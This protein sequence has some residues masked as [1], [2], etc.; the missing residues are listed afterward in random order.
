M[1]IIKAP[2]KSYAEIP[3]TSKTKFSFLKEESDHFVEL[4]YPVKCR[5]FLGDSVYSTNEGKSFIT[6]GFQ[7]PTNLDKDKTK[8]RITSEDTQEIQNILKNLDYLTNI[9]VKNKFTP[10][11]VL[12]AEPDIILLGDPKWISNVA[13][14]S[15]Y[16]YLIRRL[17]YINPKPGKIT[18]GN[19]LDYEQRLGENYQ[20]LLDNISKIAI[21]V[22][23][24]TGWSDTSPSCVHNSS[25]FVS[26][27]R[28]LT[29]NNT[30]SKLFFE[31]IVK[32]EPMPIM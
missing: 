10:T 11:V 14:I 12:Y 25:G 26:L 1:N 30:L 9:E 31:E 15:L 29:N 27:F 16:S 22:I 23:N 7:S 20:I 19:E 13:T 18:S 21:P 2:L 4:F 8:L 5:D 3:Q 6:F 24:S 28:Q 32:N 17:A